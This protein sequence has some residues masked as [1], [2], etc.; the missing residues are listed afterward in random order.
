MTQEAQPQ[1]SEK[2][3]TATEAYDS[4]SV[5]PNPENLS[6]A[7][8]GFVHLG[9]YTAVAAFVVWMRTEGRKRKEQEAKDVADLKTKS[10]EELLKDGQGWKQY[11][12]FKQKIKE[13][14]LNDEW[15]AK[16]RY[17]LGPIRSN[18]QDV[19][20]YL[21]VDGRMPTNLH[22][23]VKSSIE[24]FDRYGAAVEKDMERW[25]AIIAKESKVITK[26]TDD[27]T[28]GIAIRTVLDLDFP[29]AA[30]MG[31]YN[32]LRHQIGRVG[33]Q[34]TNPKDL[35][36]G[37]KFDVSPVGAPK[38]IPGLGQ[39]GVKQ[40]AMT[41]LLLVEFFFTSESPYAY[42]KIGELDEGDVFYENPFKND[43]ESI[44][45]GQRQR[46]HFNKLFEEM[47]NGTDAWSKSRLAYCEAMKN[48][49]LGVEKWISAS[50]L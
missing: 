45:T 4:Q 35:S 36:D 8:E 27:H 20:R 5:Q 17:E 39:D 40:A 6:V 32:K 21:S 14:Y 24:T 2:P 19:W 15:L 42:T 47:K 37:F 23:A 26:S 38:S 46:M 41:L 18:A 43:Y 31:E 1:V 3:E 28:L 49:L 25:T 44:T 48:A 33:V 13:T 12:A 29:V 34:V 10:S 7:Q 16:Q 30:H 9:I 11:E 50:I 22:A